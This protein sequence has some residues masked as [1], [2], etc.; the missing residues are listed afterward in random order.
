MTKTASPAARL[1]A[2]IAR[3]D[4]AIAKQ[5]RAAL[6]LLRK[7]MPGAVELVYD[8]YNG[9]AIAFS[10]TERLA[11]AVLSLT[12]YPRWVSLFFPHGRGLPDPE[13][14]LRG[15]GSRIRH[16]VLE[17]GAATLEEPAVRALLDA[18]LD[19]AATPLDR[20]RKRRTVIQSV[21]PKQRPRRP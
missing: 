1:A 4:P 11:D 21:S 16:V 20:G 3:Y 13:R 9:L 18:A 17:D 8:N 5:A 12:L 15:S 2:A 7:R 10:T 14:R 6:A 19:R